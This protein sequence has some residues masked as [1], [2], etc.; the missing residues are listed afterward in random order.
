[1]KYSFAG[2]L[3]VAVCLLAACHHKRDE[4]QPT[5]PSATY[6]EAS[7]SPVAIELPKGSFVV[8]AASQPANQPRRAVQLNVTLP[9]R[10]VYTMLYSFLGSSFPA[11]GAVALDA[12]VQI[13]P[14]ANAISS[15]FQDSGSQGTLRV[16]STSP[17]TISGSYTGALVAG[18]PTVRLVFNRLPL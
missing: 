2:V 3:P 18:G 17:Q 4:P 7:N 15:F 10:T 6:A 14:T 11:V 1:M 5:A 8:V 13:A 12:T 9:N 16:E